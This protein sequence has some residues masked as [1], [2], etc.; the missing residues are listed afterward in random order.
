MKFYCDTDSER[1]KGDLNVGNS[2][3]TLSSTALGNLTA[4][5]KIINSNLQDQIANIQLTPGPPGA[6]DPPGA[7]GE[8]GAQGL[9]GATGPVVRQVLL[10]RK[11]M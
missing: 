7:A 4:N 8:P 5:G 11:V 1:F 6:Q 2:L 3:N 9:V 10:E